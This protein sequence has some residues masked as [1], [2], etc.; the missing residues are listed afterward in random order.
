VRRNNIGNIHS[1]T[2]SVMSTLIGIA[3]GEGKLRLDQNLAELLPQYAAQMSPDV[4]RT[5]LRQELTMTAGFLD[6]LFSEDLS[7]M[8]SPDWVRS[9]LG[10]AVRPPG[11]LF[12]YSNRSAHLLSAILVQATGGPVLDL[13]Q[14]YLDRGA[15]GGAPGR[16]RRLGPGGHD[17]AGGQP[18]DGHHRGVWLHVVGDPG[19][20]M[21]RRSTKDSAASASELRVSAG[22]VGR[23]A[24]GCGRRASGSRPV[25]GRS[26][27]HP[28]RSGRARSDR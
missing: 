21:S 6:D 18:I 5:T 3:V 16:S 2:K 24:P 9:I 11:S 19:P 22:W 10:Q 17:R 25:P 23:P 27:R 28:G 13:G 8:T 15:L 14:L 20:G 26:R 7:Y 12:T 4:A 1:V